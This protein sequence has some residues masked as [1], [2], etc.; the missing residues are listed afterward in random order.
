MAFLINNPKKRLPQELNTLTEV[1][2]TG[3][4]N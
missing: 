3:E 1:A 4:D 2:K